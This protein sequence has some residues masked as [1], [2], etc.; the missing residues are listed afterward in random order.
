MNKLT[1]GA[2]SDWLNGEGIMTVLTDNFSVPWAGVIS[3][4]VLDDDYYGNRS[5][6]KVISP[7][8][9]KFLT[10]DGIPSDKM[11]R[12]ARVIYSKYGG[13]WA[14]SFEALNATYNPIWNVD[15]TE[16]ITTEAGSRKK[17]INKGQ[18]QNSEDFGSYTFDKGQQQNTDNIGNHTDETTNGRRESNIE[19]GVS[20]FNSPDFAD[21]NKENKV[22]NE[23]IDSVEY[24]EQEN[25]Y[26]DGAR[27]DTYG[28]RYNTLTDGAREDT[29]EDDAF[30]D[31]VTTQR[32]G[33]I[34]LTSSQN[35]IQQEMQLRTMYS[36]MDSI[37]FPDVDK[38]LTLNIF[39]DDDLTLDDF[40]IKT[41]YILPVASATKLGGVKIGEGITI[42]NDGTISVSLGNY[43]TNEQMTE[44]IATALSDYVTTDDLSDT[45]SDYITNAGLIETLGNYVT[46]TDFNIGLNTKQDTL[47]SGV[48]IKTINGV[49]ILGEGDMIIKG[50]SVLISCDTNTQNS[51]NILGFNMSVEVE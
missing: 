51:N 43:V 36:L 49:D 41:G 22:D 12:L 6:N 5:G 30:T 23:S 9:S 46:L 42:N 29:E 38:V 17:T 18:Q 24:G 45:L 25:T 35:L 21:D 2:C 20:A 33:N 32:G 26:T 50:G 15:G 19:R 14:K 8:A 28:S 47:V 13:N 3:G 7:L 40:T 11:L 1:I 48:N 16:T 4:Q 37:V 10:T 34:G 27:Q 44:A 39:G 31:V